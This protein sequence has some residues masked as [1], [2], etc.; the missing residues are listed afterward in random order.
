MKMRFLLLFFALLSTVELFSAVSVIPRKRYR[1]TFEARATKNVVPEEFRCQNAKLDYPGVEL[2]FT[3]KK[4]RKYVRLAR[5]SF[6]NLHSREF[7]PGAIEFFAGEGIKLVKLVPKNAEVRNVKIV[8]VKNN[9]NLAIPLDYRV[10]GQVRELRLAGPHVEAKVVGTRKDAYRVTIDF[11]VPDDDAAGRIVSRIK[12]EPMLAAR[13]LVGD[14]PTEIEMFF[15]DE[16]YD[17]FPGGRI[18]KGRY[19]M[20]TA[21]SCPDYANPCK[22]SAAVLLILGEEIA[23]RPATLLELR[24]ISMEELCGED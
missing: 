6:F 13:I 16:G 19:D 2:Q 21:C 5:G 4:N 12:D 10:S 11:R 14:L 1:A 17:L 15:R 9:S 18:A 22:H 3:D 7:V 8:P 20:T 24:G 23:R